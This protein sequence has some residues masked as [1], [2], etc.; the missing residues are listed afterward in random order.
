MRDSVDL[1]TRWA[2][3]V[4]FLYPL[5]WGCGPEFTRIVLR[6]AAL[7]ASRTG[8]KGLVRRNDRRDA[9]SIFLSFDRSRA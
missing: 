1:S 9:L 8:A 6:L 7:V 4:E 3:V 2:R 5:A